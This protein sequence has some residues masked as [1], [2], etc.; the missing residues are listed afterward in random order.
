MKGL[1][2]RALQLLMTALGRMAAESPE[3]R[4]SRTI[5]RVEKDGGYL[6]KC[7]CLVGAKSGELRKM[8]ANCGPE[9]VLDLEAEVSRSHEPGPWCRSRPRRTAV[10][11][12]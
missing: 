2:A 10:T 12:P 9:S 5:V 11:R 6:L 3:R 7:G 4:A 1:L 8:A